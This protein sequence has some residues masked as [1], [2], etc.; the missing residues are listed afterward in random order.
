MALSAASSSSTTH[1]PT[2]IS[3]SLMWGNMYFPLMLQ[4][5]LVRACCWRYLSTTSTAGSKSSSLFLA[6]AT[7]N[8]PILNLTELNPGQDFSRTFKVARYSFLVWW[9]DNPS[10]LSVGKG[11]S[12][13]RMRNA[14]WPICLQ[15]IDIKW[16][17]RSLDISLPWSQNLNVLLE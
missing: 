12:T 11:I 1:H 16:A 14:F 3:L 9:D 7:A 15:I 8:I 6:V 17:W 13:C 10:K 4:M 5:V 2:V